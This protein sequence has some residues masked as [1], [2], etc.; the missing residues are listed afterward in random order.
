VDFFHRDRLKDT[1]GYGPQ[2]EHG[3]TEARRRRT[4]DWLD[5]R[6]FNCRRPKA[7]TICT[8]FD[9]GSP[10]DN[11]RNCGS[12]GTKI[13]RPDTHMGTGN[14]RDPYRNIGNEHYERAIVVVTHY[15]WSRGFN[16][17]S[18]SI[19]ASPLDRPFQD[20]TP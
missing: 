3:T 15:F 19:Q 18:L 13:K 16:G 12:G 6:G 17:I 2:L 11:D 7:I 5:C 4:A 20:F 8:L 14:C 1:D 10:G 9:A